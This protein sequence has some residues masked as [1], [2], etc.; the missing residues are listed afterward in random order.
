MQPGTTLFSL[1]TDPNGIFDGS[2]A[3]VAIE[4]SVNTKV[5]PTSGGLTI[6]N[7]VVEIAR[8]ANLDKLQSFTLEATVT[9]TKIGPDRQNIAEA[10]T[11][12]I[13]LFIGP[14]GQLVGSMLINGAW[15]WRG[16]GQ[17]EGRRESRRPGAFYAG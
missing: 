8:H 16:L 10:Q 14:D 11:P 13:A 1:R 5:L 17:H 12:G 2:N 3:G 15:G 9:P 7:G 6:S 4:R